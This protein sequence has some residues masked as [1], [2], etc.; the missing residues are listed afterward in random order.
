M[1]TFEA[2]APSKV[3]GKSPERNIEAFPAWKS[4]QIFQL[5]GDQHQRPTG[6][7]L[8]IRLV[9]PCVSLFLPACLAQNIFFFDSCLWM[10]YGW[11]PQTRIAVEES[12]VLKLNHRTMGLVLSSRTWFISQVISRPGF[13]AT[14]YQFVGIFQPNCCNLAQKYGKDGGLP[15]DKAASRWSVGSWIAQSP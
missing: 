3:A 7:L 4:F 8:G 5:N 12:P 6:I 9:F 1:Q 10:N 13:T 2:P 14:S 11:Y 15:M